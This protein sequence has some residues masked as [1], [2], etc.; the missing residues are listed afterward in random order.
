MNYHILVQDKFFDS[1]ID[2]FYEIGEEKNNIFL[3]RGNKGD[4]DYIKTTH[5]VEY[6]GHDAQSIKKRLHSIPPQDNIFIHW[7]DMFIGDIVYDLP[8]KLFV[9]LMGGDFYADPIECNLDFLYDKQTLKSVYRLNKHLRSFHLRRNVFR[10]FA[11]W[12]NREKIIQRKYDLKHKHISRID[13]ILCL[14]EGKSELKFIKKKY[15][16]FKATHLSFNFNQNFDETISIKKEKNNS[17]TTIKILLGN[18]SDP[19]NNH[20]DAFKILQKLNIPVEIYSPI[21]YGDIRYRDT[22]INKGKKFFGEHFHPITDFMTRKEYI[23]FID[24]VDLMMM[25]HNRSQA[26]GNINIALT[27][28]KAVFLKKNNSIFDFYCKLGIKC[29]DV[30]KITNLNLDK[31]IKEQKK[32]MEHNLLIL[33]NV[34]SKERR[35]NDLKK[36]LYEYC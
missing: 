34:N 24:S 13:Y 36:I 17:S 1:Y 2:D 4:N 19:S 9:S 23:E 14:A 16:N 11:N 7:Y 22:I 29:Y 3:F 12:I 25:Y 31:I 26:V 33:N 27:L 30:H 18:S 15:P 35:L 21:S 32:S 8:N 5:P 20:L 28:G 10:I 6:L